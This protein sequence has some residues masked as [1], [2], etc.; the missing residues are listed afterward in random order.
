MRRS[1]PLLGLTLGLATACAADP[2]SSRHESAAGAAVQAMMGGA[3]SNPTQAIDPLAQQRALL[4]SVLAMPS[5]PGAP[6]FEA[7][8]AE[9]VARA[10]GEPVVFVRTPRSASSMEGSADPEM[11]GLM[12]ATEQYGAVRQALKRHA[13]RHARL[14]E[15]LLRE[16]YLYSENPDQA[17]ALLSLVGPQHLFEEDEI[18]I[19]RGEQVMHAK[20]SRSGYVFTDGPHAGEKASLMHL[21]RVGTGPVP[22]ALHR[23]LRSL[24]YRLH[25]DEARVEHMTESRLV[26]RLRYG[27]HWVR[28]VVR[29]VDARL[30]LE[31]EL[32]EPELRPEVDVA[33]QQSA[34]RQASLQSLREAMAQQVTERLPFDEPK[35]EFDQE[36]GTLRNLWRGAY[37]AGHKQFEYNWDTYRVFSADGVPMVP[38][39]CIDFIVDTFERASGTWWNSASA[40]PGRQIGGLDLREL[41]GAKLRRNEY[42]VTFAREHSEWFDVLELAPEQRVA[43]GNK[44]KF[45]AKLSEQVDDFQS[46]DVVLIHGYTPWD[47][48]RPHSHA[49]MI[50]ET[51]PITRMP[52]LIAGN[53]GPANLWSMETEARRAPLRSIR[54][55]VRPKQEWLSEVLLPPVARDEPLPLL[56]RPRS[57]G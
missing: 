47:D 37:L 54:Y 24:K 45:F 51:D 49:F 20:R 16:G 23:D 50:Y 4:D 30:E 7:H 46:G 34:E 33:R 1:L 5:L 39:V 57:G 32:V 41:A 35:T 8:R 40:A 25:F 27:E 56:R 6:G 44:S 53:A 19:H 48:E 14:R 22:A 18:W 13:G 10:K 43:M 11:A 12:G 9:L 3:D 2:D 52:I 29:S 17:F 28:S 36:D 21:D 38:Q 15:M 42:F 55:R 26:M 31:A